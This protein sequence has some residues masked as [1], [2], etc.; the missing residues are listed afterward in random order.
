M[1]ADLKFY[2]ALFLRRLHYFL[3]VAIAVS[4]V[5]V[6]IAYTLPP[7]YEAE[8]RLL[9][10]SPQIPGNLARSTVQASASEIL[11]IIRQRLLT[12]ANMLEIAREFEVFQNDRNMS[13]DAIVAGMR[14]RISMRLPRSR[15]AA[16]FVSISFQA[17]SGPL[18]A[19]IANEL[20]TR[21]LEQNVSLRK[22]AAG[23]TLGFFEREV[24]RLDRELADQGQEILEFKLRNQNALPD[25]LNFR[26]S[27]LASLQERLVQT[28]RQLVSLN[29]RRARLQE[30]YERNGS[31]FFDAEKGLTPDQKR[32]RELQNSLSSARA[33]YSD[34][35]PRI[36]FLRRQIDV[37]EEKIM[38]A[39]SAGLAASEN[40]LTPFEIQ[41]EDLQAQ[42]DLLTEQKASI[43]TQ[44]EDLEKT[45]QAT[46]AN[47]VTLGTLERDYENLRIQYNQATA[48]LAAARTGDQIEAQSRGQR[49]SVIEQAV[50][51]NKPTSPNRGRIAA[52]GV[53]GGIFAG[54]GLIALLELLNS[55]IRRPADLRNQLGIN[56]FVTI[57]YI[58]TRKQLLVR[59]A[60]IGV[61]IL[62]A[63]IGIPGILFYVDQN[64]MPMDMLLDQI[65]EKSG[66]SDILVRLGLSL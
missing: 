34:Q 46:P 2:L 17:D 66:L 29:D 41:M 59:R 58:R 52:A 11:G 4:S 33:I 43:E 16:A 65:A 53:G 8:A 20:V 39:Q 37:L 27:R 51:P 28:E 1:L 48:D 12:R 19:R 3:V 23:E 44:L 56:P 25:S 49:I 40:A 60:I 7:V 24:E 32:L 55:S 35:N 63:A 62:I 64:V 5:G 26:R 22:A 38:E 21:V 9:V 47:A 50:A 57:P 18:S 31:A 14:S 42:M 36:E 61:A 15:D 10:E 54:I 6:T 13:P 30:M 45:I